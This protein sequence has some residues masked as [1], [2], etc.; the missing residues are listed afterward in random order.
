VVD[1]GAHRGEFSAEIMRKFGCKCHMIEANPALA[2]GLAR[3]GA[4]TITC[5]ALSA[6]DGSARLQLAENLESSSLQINVENPGENSVEIKTISLATFI[7]QLCSDRID[8]LKMD[9]E[10][11]EFDVIATTP[12]TVLRRIGQ[13]TVEFHDFQSRFKGRQLF[14]TARKKLQSLG[15]ACIVMSFR[16]HGDVLFLNKDSL[17][18]SSL[19]AA[20]LRF[21]A[22][23]VEKI[24]ARAALPTPR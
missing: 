4:A 9:I 19:S 24:N 20:Y 2:G 21:A 22:R 10:G 1:A 17:Q 13:L 7:Q 16:T 12:D 14:E 5:A 3:A 15:F 23:F 18:L 11:A 6:R 8:L